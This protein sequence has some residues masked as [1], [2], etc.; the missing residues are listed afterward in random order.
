MDKPLLDFAKERRDKLLPISADSNMLNEE[1]NRLK[2]RTDNEEPV[3]NMLATENRCCN[4]TW[5]SNENP[6]PNL[7]KERKE[8]LLPIHNCCKVEIAD[9]NRV[10]DRKLQDDPS[11]A[12]SITEILL[13]NRRMPA[14]EI[15]LPIFTIF[16]IEI[17]DPA[18]PKSVILHA[19][20]NRPKDRTERELPTCK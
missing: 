16:R 13:P 1:P 14:S 2:L 6:L 15:P 5:P 11:T 3:S 20:P 10:N 9:P 7:A 17:E 19:A 4:F 18:C 8:I 12:M